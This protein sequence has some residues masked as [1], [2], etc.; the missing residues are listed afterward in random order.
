M[1]FENPRL[2][3]ICRYWTNSTKK[4]AQQK[5][6]ARPVFRFCFAEVA[7]R[8]RVY[9][10]ASALSPPSSSAFLTFFFFFIAIFW[11]RTLGIPR[12]ESP[13]FQRSVAANLARRSARVSTLRCF[14]PPALILRLLSIVISS[15][16]GFF[17][18]RDYMDIIGLSQ[19]LK[20]GICPHETNVSPGFGDWHD[21]Q[22]FP[23]PQNAP[24]SGKV[25]LLTSV[26]RSGGICC[27]GFV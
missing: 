17:G 5:C 26:R 13:S 3:R 8:G 21:Q 12:T 15:L 9:S 11:T 1:S 24:V 18:T 22:T 14:T 4:A 2:R 19:V 7:N 20:T 25:C 16:F 10:E 27:D 23:E 6:V